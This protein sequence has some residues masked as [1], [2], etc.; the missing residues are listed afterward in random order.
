MHLTEKISISESQTRNLCLKHT[1]IRTL[2]VIAENTPRNIK[3]KQT[4]TSVFPQVGFEEGRS[5]EYTQL[6]SYPG[7]TERP[8]SKN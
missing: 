4:T 8:F 6:Y 3:N 1:F 5:V 2:S 7:Q